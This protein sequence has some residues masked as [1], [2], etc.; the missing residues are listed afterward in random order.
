MQTDL[1]QARWQFILQPVWWLLCPTK[2]FF[3]T[4]GEVFI[5]E[6]GIFHFMSANIKLAYT[7]ITILCFTC[8]VDEINGNLMENIFVTSLISSG[9]AYTGAPIFRA[10]LTAY[11]ALERQSWW[12]KYIF[13]TF[14]MQLKLFVPLLSAWSQSWRRSSRSRQ[15]SWH[16]WDQWSEAPSCSSCLGSVWSGSSSLLHSAEKKTSLVQYFNFSH[17]NKVKQLSCAFSVHK[18]LLFAQE[19]ISLS[20][21]GVPSSLSLERRVRL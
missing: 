10:M 11:F 14:A 20:T 21:I 2:I 15:S 19:M 18:T 17:K 13:A 1:L 7:V 9:R 4:L 8:K 3:L 6:F 16:R 5:R 12:G